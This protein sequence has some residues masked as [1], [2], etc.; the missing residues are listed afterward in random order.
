M[1]FMYD[2]EDVSRWDLKPLYN[3]ERAWDENYETLLK[4]G[5]DA[6]IKF[7]GL[8]AQDPANLEASLDAFFNFNEMLEKLYTYAH[9]LSDGDIG[10]QQNLIRIN[11]ARSLYSDFDAN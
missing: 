2:H 3:D 4:Q 6:V 11:Q 7:R 5:F 8:L 10:D 1:A 9:L